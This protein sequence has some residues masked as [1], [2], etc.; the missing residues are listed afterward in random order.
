MPMDIQF[1]I[2]IIPNWKLSKSKEKNGRQH[3]EI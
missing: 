2:L 1:Q 3:S